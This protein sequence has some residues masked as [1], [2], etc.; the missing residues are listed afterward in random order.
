[1]IATV[2][3]GAAG[4]LLGAGAVHAMPRPAEVP[5]PL[6][7]VLARLV[8][9]LRRTV[10]MLREVGSVRAPL[11]PSRMRR[12]RVT[13][14]V[15]GAAAG[16]MLFG[17][18]GGAL[19]AAIATWA[20]PRMVA[21][22]RRRWGRRLDEGAG[23][24][25]RAIANAISA[26]ASLRTSVAVAARRLTG[27]IAEELGRTAWELE[28]GA[29]TEAALERL[30]SRSASGAVA[31]IVAAMQV[32]RRS[33]GDLARVLRDVATAL[34]QDWQVIEE[35]DAA[36]AQARFTAIVVVALPVCGIGLGALASPGLPARM[37]GSPFGA[38]LLL[39]SL[40]LQVCG[41]LL[42]RRLA[43]SWV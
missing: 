19:C 37:A 7:G 38:A 13:A 20:A 41:A 34:E 32:Q 17:W 36:T 15:A 25:A 10:D 4:A 9:E 12:L 5:F 11:P 14:A 24:A 2:L 33:G 39:A 21:A 16:A 40:A 6:R 18:R 1:V 35:A 43:R 22:R 26:G 3:A 42:I 29:A 23:P 31:L 8:D 27:P 30:R 28:M